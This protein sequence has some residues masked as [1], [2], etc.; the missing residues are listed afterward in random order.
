MG[1]I[2]YNLCSCQINLNNRS[3]RTIISL[4]VRY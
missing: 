2:Y 3:T 4:D 1:N